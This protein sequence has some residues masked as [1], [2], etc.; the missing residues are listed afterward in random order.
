MYR[1]IQYIHWVCTIL[2]LCS[3]FGST[4]FGRKPSLYSKSLPMEC[5][6][7]AGEWDQIE[8]LRTRLR[9][10]HK[11]CLHPVSQEFCEPTRAN[12]VL[13]GF[14]LLPVLER[15]RGTENLKLPYLEPLKKEIA[16]LFTKCGVDVT[17]RKIYTTSIEI[18]RLTG[19]VKRRMLRK[20]VTKDIC[21]KTSAL[22][23]KW[24]FLQN[25]FF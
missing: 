11:L 15:L 13:N 12:C 25:Y 9:E 16:L 14:V 18:K 5:G 23:L 19:F 7:L 6:G 20:E 4:V 8:D 2:V 17:D 1:D 24:F 22:F 10:E 3:C 21:L